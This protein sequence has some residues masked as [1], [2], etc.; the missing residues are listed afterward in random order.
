MHSMLPISLR[1]STS[2]LRDNC[3]NPFSLFFCENTRNDL[4]AQNAR[5]VPTCKWEWI[6]LLLV[7][8]YIFFID[9]HWKYS[10]M[11][12]VATKIG[13]LDTHFGNCVKLKWLSVFSCICKCVRTN[14]LCKLTVNA[15]HFLSMLQWHGFIH[16]LGPAL[17]QGVKSLLP[18]SV[19]SVSVVKFKN[20]RSPAPCCSFLIGF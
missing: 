2:L 12:F 19:K 8:D 4:T 17:Y 14:F 16:L 1:D 3:K 7:D 9:S 6:L 10:S 13:V 20:S 15:A 11:W 5:F 18:S